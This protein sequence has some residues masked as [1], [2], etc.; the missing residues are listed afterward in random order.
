MKEE[1]KVYEFRSEISERL[2]CEYRT[3]KFGS[4]HKFQELIQI[5]EDALKE[6]IL[7]ITYDFPTPLLTKYSIDYGMVEE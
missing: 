7:K 1:K 5:C 3:D 4:K 2:N 6:S